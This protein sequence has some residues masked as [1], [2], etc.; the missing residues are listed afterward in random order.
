MKLI[1]SPLG[2]MYGVKVQPLWHPGH[3]CAMLDGKGEEAQW[4]LLRPLPSL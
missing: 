3:S 2:E 4:P 1:A